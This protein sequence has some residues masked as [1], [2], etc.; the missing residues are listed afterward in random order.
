M[1]IPTIVALFA[2][3]IFSGSVHAEENDT[4]LTRL[5]ELHRQRKW[6]ELVEQFEQENLSAW[7]TA[8][9]ASEALYLRGQAHAILKSGAKAEA[10][11]KSALQR[12]PHNALVAH[13]LAENYVNNLHD[14]LQALDAYRQVFKL[15]G[16]SNGWL[17]I[18][19]TL[20][21]ARL[22]T[23]QVKTDE[24]LEVLG[25]YGDMAGMPPVWQSKMLRAYGQ[26]YAAQGKDA[27]SLAYFRQALQLESAGSPLYAGTAKV[28]ITPAAES[29]VDLLGRPLEARDRLYARVLI[30]KNDRSSLA[31]VSV[32]LVVFAS[33]KV[34]AQAKAQCGVDHVVLCATHTH[35][36]M[37]PRGLII[38]PPTARD[39]TRG[40]VAPAELVDWPSLSADPWYAATEAKIVEAIGQAKQNLFR[41][42]VVSGRGSFESVYMAHNRRLVGDGRV[43]PLWQNPERRPTQAVDPT[44]GVIRVDDESGKPRALAIHYACHP[45]VTMGAG[46]LSRDFPGAAVD[47]LEQEL[48]DN[49]LGMFLQGASGDLNPYDLHNLHGENRFNM[50][51]QAG[52]S[53]AKRALQVAT[54]LNS[55]PESTRVDLEVRESLLTIPNRQGDKSTDVAILTAVIHREL[56]LVTIPGEPFVQHQ[57]NLRA[58]SPISNTFLLGL[59]YC[60]QGTPF[61][62]Y[63]PTV[64]AVKEGGYGAGECSFLAAD[65][66]Q[67]MVAESLLQLGEVIS[68]GR[69]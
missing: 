47:Y 62:V 25:Q 67:R 39:W 42:H 54:G 17:P 5:R 14:D 68:S 28:E 37:A 12:T 57:L 29:A 61:V 63:I 16:K 19:T 22:L 1:K 51:R 55:Q 41:A 38:N 44:L 35:A 49:C 36:G 27:E 18:S 15:T 21:I 2:L 59:A 69:K 31:I 40:S 53:L 43:I 64:Q 20:S 9:E 65:A 46:E 45:V 66:G 13:G 11:F 58:N 48:G 23:D 34:I 24:A 3:S 50:A 56:A 7:P 32:D 60:G 4:S 33:A 10:D 52:I 6:R 26:A 8:G 30:L